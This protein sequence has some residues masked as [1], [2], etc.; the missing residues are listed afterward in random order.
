MFASFTYV[1][2]ESVDVPEEVLEL[3]FAR[4]NCNKKVAMPLDNSA[5]RWSMGGNIFHMV[6]NKCFESSRVFGLGSG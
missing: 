1:D 4:F 2:V 5:E 6:S 3:A